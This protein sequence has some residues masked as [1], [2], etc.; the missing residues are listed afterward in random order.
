MHSSPGKH[1]GVGNTVCAYKV[2]EEEIDGDGDDDNRTVIESKTKDNDEGDDGHLNYRYADDYSLP[3]FT[4]VLSQL[5][6]KTP[7]LQI[8]SAE[9][10]PQGDGKLELRFLSLLDGGIMGGHYDAVSLHPV[11]VD[12]LHEAIESNEGSYETPIVKF[13]RQVIYGT[14][15]TLRIGQ[16]ECERKMRIYQATS[17]YKK[18]NGVKLLGKLQI[19]L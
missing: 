13:L 18:G 15:W 6:S 17:S 7:S 11:A 8:E 4:A 1:S 19:S 9:I 12:K 16:E 5:T 3:D 10:I 14:S 2:E